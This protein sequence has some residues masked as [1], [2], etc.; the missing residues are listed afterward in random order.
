MRSRT[1]R[2]R[3]ADRGFEKNMLLVPGWATDWRIFEKLDIPFN[4]LLLE[5]AVFPATGDIIKYIPGVILS[6]GIG[7]LGWSMGGFIA[8]DLIVKY[9]GLFE[10]VI[11]VSIRRKYDVSEIEH[12]RVCLKKNARAYL[13]SFYNAL[14]SNDEKENRK[15]F[16]NNLFNKYV[17]EMSCPSLLEGLD[18]LSTAELRISSLNNP[19]TIF[20][21]GEDDAIAP[22]VETQALMSQAPRAQSL[23]I[24]GAC[25]LPFLHKEI[26][27]IF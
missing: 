5:K 18:Y 3:F 10:K 22:I 19:N 7:M 20:I 12:A 25:H 27:S 14:F 8:S 9:P 11:L 15:W 17:E 1:P 6:A 16:R 26:G 4:Y 23:I 2:F 13:Y 21:H 24:K